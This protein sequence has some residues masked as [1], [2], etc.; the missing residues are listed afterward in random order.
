MLTK[1]SERF[2]KSVQE[3]FGTGSLSLGA[4]IEA[5]TAHFSTEFDY[6]KVKA[7]FK[8]RRKFVGSGQ[9]ITNIYSSIKTI[10]VKKKI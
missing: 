4:I 9:T 2:L 10:I 1:T 8:S 6:R 3:R 5:T 7:F